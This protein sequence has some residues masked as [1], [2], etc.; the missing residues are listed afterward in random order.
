[1]STVAQEEG[2]CVIVRKIVVVGAGV[3][4]C[5]LAREL[6]ST[7]HTEVSVLE[8]SPAGRLSGSTP[9]APGFVGLYNDDP[10]LTGLARA[11]AEIYDSIGTGFTRAGGVEIA[12]SE[13][14]SRE[15]ARR[16]AS[17]RE[18]GLTVEEVDPRGAARLAP[19]VI[20]P[21]HVV[22][23]WFYPLDATAQPREL[24]GALRAEATAQGANFLD[25]TQATGIKRSGNGLE[26]RTSGG[27]H[28]VDD[29]VLTGGVWGPGLTALV[30]I[31]LPL[32][33][34][35]H[36]YV[37]S[38]PS[39]R[40]ASGPFVRWPEHHVYARVHGDRLGIGTY[41]HVPQPVSQEELEGGASLAWRSDPFDPALSAAMQL[42]PEHSR[43]APERR[44]N[45]VFA[46]TPDN[47]PLVGPHPTVPGLWSAQAVWVT[48]AAGTARALADAITAGEYL[49]SE[50]DPTRF[51]GTPREALQASA[52]QLYRDIYATETNR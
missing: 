9:Y 51:G 28:V 21:V 48:H 33:P 34:V 10:V 23:A 36:P 22:S 5:A 41:D 11:S 43:F 19:S 12:T 38:P 47:L 18:A 8:R 16:A 31:D 14:G 29:V 46:M 1:M 37:Y 32:F 35:A 17:A 52:L 50:L 44:V 24:T 25:G 2:R 27:T 7:G 15:L 45:G 49:P 40:H 6:S 26:L 30:G 3:V 4:G 42:L 13:P 20:D 39:R